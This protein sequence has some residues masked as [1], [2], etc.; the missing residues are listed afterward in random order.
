MRGGGWGV[1]KRWASELFE[2]L[3]AAVAVWLRVD[4]FGW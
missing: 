3:T 2:G 1:G 4:V